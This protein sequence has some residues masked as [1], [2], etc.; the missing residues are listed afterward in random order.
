MKTVVLILVVLV[1]GVVML[2]V[3]VQPV[4]A[5][6]NP[7]TDTCTGGEIGDTVCTYKVYLNDIRNHVVGNEPVFGFPCQGGEQCLIGVIG[8]TP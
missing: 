6:S 8:V 5:G 7:L 3:A 2:L 1:V 4:D